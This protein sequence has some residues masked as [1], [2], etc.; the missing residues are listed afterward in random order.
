MNIAHLFF[1]DGEEIAA[2]ATPD[3]ARQLI[4]NGVRNLF[5]IDLVERLQKDLQILERRRQG[6]IMP[7]ENNEVIRQKEKELESLDKQI[8][9]MVEKKSSSAN[10]GT[11][12]CQE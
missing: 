8:E 7:V 9:R 5:G 2:Y 10:R 11:I 12:Q 6:T 4:A 1:F 3:G